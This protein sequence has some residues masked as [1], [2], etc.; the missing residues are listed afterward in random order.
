MSPIMRRLIHLPLSPFCRKIRLVLAE[1]KL[2]VDLIE[3]PV[4]ERRIELIRLNPAAMVPILKN[5]NLILSESNAIFEFLE[6]K[7]PKPALLP[8]S[9]LDRAEAR[10]INFWFDDK[11][12]SEVTSRLLYERVNKKLA[13]SGE[14][15]SAIIKSGMKNFKFHIEYMD[16][17]LQKRRWLAGDKLTIADFS[18][19]AH[20]S[21][22][23]YIGTVDWE[24][25]VNIK[26][27][28]VKLKS[29]PAFRSLLA[30]LVPGFS[31]PPYYSDLDF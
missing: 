6:E 16:W 17:L 10:R 11:F 8:E 12:H 7:Y 28:Y 9:L 2:Q 5:E 1:K 23:D 24:M 15:D 26:D 13:K 3:E 30:D 4:W 14:P 21:S 19:A 27:W 25:S 31:P 29:R 22:L 20:F 18:A